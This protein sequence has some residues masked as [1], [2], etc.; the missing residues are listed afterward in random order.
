MENNKNKKILKRTFQGIVVSDK[1]DKTIVVRVDRIKCH[2]KYKKRYKTSKR[3][4]VHDSE[5]KYKTGEK[6][7][8]IECRPLSKEKKWRVKIGE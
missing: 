5:N 1:M 6:V 8:F 4:K 3:Y 2:P 7:T